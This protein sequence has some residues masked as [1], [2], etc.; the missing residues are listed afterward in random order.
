MR[1]GLPAFGCWALA[2]VGALAGCS[3]Y[4]LGT[5]GRLAFTT[6][7]VAPVQNRTL[8]PQAQAAISTQLRT[9]LIQD[10]RVQLVNSPSAADATLQVVITDFH[11][12][13]AAQREQDTGLA[14]KFVETV[15]TSCTLRDNRSGRAL[16]ENR[17]VSIQRAVFTDNG[18]PHSLTIGDQQLAE[19]NTIPLFAEALANK[20]SHTVLDVW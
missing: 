20:I 2:A 11:R 6:L 16:F 13:V 8:L 5:Q 10:G 1:H 17:L 18:D 15:G 4:E 9:D 19:Y 14:S 3:H 7:Y 12:D